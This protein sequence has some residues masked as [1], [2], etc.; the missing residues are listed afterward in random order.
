MFKLAPA[1][2]LEYLN[3]YFQVQVKDP[4][5]ETKISA[6]SLTADVSDKHLTPAGTFYISAETRVTFAEPSHPA[7]GAPVIPLGPTSITCAA[8]VA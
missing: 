1:L 6:F 5:E 3:C 7:A 4:E 2:A 8:P